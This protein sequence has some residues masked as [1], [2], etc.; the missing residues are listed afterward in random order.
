MSAVALWNLGQTKGPFT[1]AKFVVKISTVFH[2]NYACFTYLGHASQNDT[3][4][5]APPKGSS[6]HAMWI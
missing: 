5:V 3:L 4:C 1:L 2:Y 6:T